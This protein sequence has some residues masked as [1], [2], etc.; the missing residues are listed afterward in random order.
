MPFVPPYPILHGCFALTIGLYIMGIAFMSLYYAAWHPGR[1]R[2]CFMVGIPYSCDCCYVFRK[3]PVDNITGNVDLPLDGD[4]EHGNR[5]RVNGVLAA[6]EDAEVS[7][8]DYDPMINL[9]TLA[10][11]RSSFTIGQLSRSLTTTPHRHPSTWQGNAL[12]QRTKHW[13]GNAWLQ[14][15]YEI[16]SSENW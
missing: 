1:T 11:R 5:S 7:L 9:S 16:R 15:T 12:Y 6:T 4:S 8:T 2:D 14:I 10:E 13:K 3:P